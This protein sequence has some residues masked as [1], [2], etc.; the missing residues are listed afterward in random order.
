[1]PA[2]YNKNRFVVA[3]MGSAFYVGVSGVFRRG[4]SRADAIHLATWLIIQT[5]CSAEEIK[6]TIADLSTDGIG[7]DLINTFEK[8]EKEIEG[9]V[10]RIVNEVTE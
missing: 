2:D 3:P 4:M 5:K 6:L 10:V 7:Q 1:M 8:E 9:K